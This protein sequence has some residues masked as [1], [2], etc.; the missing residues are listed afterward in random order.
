[1]LAFGQSAL[2]NYG[3]DYSDKTFMMGHENNRQ[4]KNLTSKYMV[5]VRHQ[6]LKNRFGSTPHGVLDSLVFFK[7]QS[8]GYAGFGKLNIYIKTTN[9]TFVD[10]LSW[11]FNQQKLSATQVFKSDRFR[12]DDASGPLVLHT[13]HRF[14]Y[15][16]S[17]NLMILVEWTRPD[18]ISCFKTRWKGK[19]VTDRTSMSW[20]GV[21]PKFS[22]TI[23][24]RFKVDM[25]LSFDSTAKICPDQSTFK[26]GEING[27]KFTVGLDTQNLES[28]LYVNFR[29]KNQEYSVY[30]NNQFEHLDTVN[31]VYPSTVYHV[32]TNNHCVPKGYQGE[33]HS[34]TIKTSCSIDLLDHIPYHQNFE[35]M[36]ADFGYESCWEY[37]DTTLAEDANNPHTGRHALLL[38]HNWNEWA[39]TPKIWLTAGTNYEVS[40]KYASE[41]NTV[42]VYIILGLDSVPIRNNTY[43]KIGEINRP[44]ND[45]YKTH[46]TVFSANKTGYY[47]LGIIRTGS[48]YKRVFIDD[49]VIRVHEACPLPELKSVIPGDHTIHFDFENDAAIEEYQVRVFNDDFDSTYV[50]SSGSFNTPGLLQNTSYFYESAS[51]CKDE[52]SSTT[53]AIRSILTLCKI[54]TLNRENPNVLQDYEDLTCIEDYTRIGSYIYT[55]QQGMSGNCVAGRNYTRLIGNH[56]YLQKNDTVLLEVYVAKEFQEPRFAGDSVPLFAYFVNGDFENSDTLNSTLDSIFFGEYKRAYTE[57]VASSEGIYSFGVGSAVRHNI[58]M[59]NFSISLRNNACNDV[60]NLEL[61][62]TQEDLL[63][64]KWSYEKPG[65]TS[66]FF[67]LR[68][69]KDV[70]IRYFSTADTSIQITGLIPRS[71][72]TV[73]MYFI[74]GTDTLLGQAPFVYHTPCALDT[75]KPNRPLHIDFESESEIKCFSHVTKDWLLYTSPG[76]EAYQRSRN[77]RGYFYIEKSNSTPTFEINPVYLT[78]DVNYGISALFAQDAQESRIWI[79]VIDSAGIVIKKDQLVLSPSDGNGSVY[80]EFT[81]AYSGIYRI[82]FKTGLRISVDDITVEHLD[83]C[84]AI[85]SQNL[86]VTSSGDTTQILLKSIAQQITRLDIRYGLTGTSLTYID[87]AVDSSRSIHLDLVLPGQSLFDLT[88]QTFCTNTNGTN[89]SFQFL[90][91]QKQVDTI[92]GTHP[93]QLDFDEYPAGKQSPFVDNGE[94]LGSPQI[95]IEENVGFPALSGSELI[96]ITQGLNE[97]IIPI[98]YFDTGII[99]RFSCFL[100]ART[101]QSKKVTLIVINQNYTDTAYVSNSVVNFGHTYIEI[102]RQFSINKPG[103]YAVKLQIEDR[104]APIFMDNLSITAS[105]LLKTPVSIVEWENSY[106]QVSLKWQHERKQEFDH[107]ELS[108]YERDSVLSGLPY[109]TITSIATSDSIV[110][111][112]GLP[113]NKEFWFRISGQNAQN[114]N[115]SVSP[116]QMVHTLATLDSSALRYTIRYTF[117]ASSQYGVVPMV[118]DTAS[119]AVLQAQEVALEYGYS[120]LNSLSGSNYINHP[121]YLLKDSVYSMSIAVRPNSRYDSKIYFSIDSI[122][123]SSQRVSLSDTF[124]LVRGTN[125]NVFARKFK[126]NESGYRKLSCSTILPNAQIHFDDFQ[127][128][129]SDPCLDQVDQMLAKNAVG[130]DWVEIQWRKPSL[131]SGYVVETVSNTSITRDTI[132]TIND[133]TY[134]INGLDLESI[135]SIRVGNQCGDLKWSKPIAHKTEPAVDTITNVRSYETSFEQPI[136]EK[137]S[138]LMYASQLKRTDITSAE[139]NYSLNYRAKSSTDTVRFLFAKV[140]LKAGKEYTV[141]YNRA[142]FNQSHENAVLYINDTLTT[143]GATAIGT[144]NTSQT[145]WRNIEFNK[146][147]VSKTGVYYIILESRFDHPFASLYLDDIVIK[148]HH[149]CKTFATLNLSIDRLTSNSATFSINNGYSANL[150][151]TYDLMTRNLGALVNYDHNYYH[152]PSGSTTIELKNLNTYTDYQISISAR[153]DVSDTTSYITPLPF[154]LTC[155]DSIH[156]V[157]ASNSYLENFEA[158][159]TNVLP[160]CW[161]G[162]S[163]FSGIV[164]T[165]NSNDRTLDWELR[166]YGGGNVTSKKLLLDSGVN[167]LISGDYTVFAKGGDSITIEVYDSKHQRLVDYE[168]FGNSTKASGLKTFQ[169]KFKPQGTSNYYLKLWNNSRSTTWISY[170]HFDEIS[171]QTEP[172]CKLDNVQLLPSSTG[173]K[174]VIISNSNTVSNTFVV[175]NKTLITTDTI[176]VPKHITYVDIPGSGYNSYQFEQQTSCGTSNS[177]KAF[178]TFKASNEAID[179]GEGWCEAFDHLLA[180]ELQDGWYATGVRGSGASNR[181]HST[182]NISFENTGHVPAVRSY[183]RNT[184][185]WDVHYAESPPI[186]FPYGGAFHVDMLY[187]VNHGEFD[188]Y[189]WNK[190]GADSISFA[191]YDIAEDSVIY[192][193]KPKVP[194]SQNA[195]VEYSADLYLKK[196]GNF[197]LRVY[198]HIQRPYVTN[199]NQYQKVYVTFDDICITPFDQEDCAAPRTSNI[200]LDTTLKQHVISWE[201]IPNAYSGYEWYLSNALDTTPIFSGFTFNQNSTRALLPDIPVG[202]SLRLFVRANCADKLDSQEVVRGGKTKPI[203]SFWSIGQPIIAPCRATYVDQE[204]IT[205]AFEDNST[206][207]PEC[208]SSSGDNSKVS[209]NHG[210]LYGKDSRGFLH[211][212]PQVNSSLKTNAFALQ[213]DS[214]YTISFDLMT[215]GRYSCDSILF[216]L[217]NQFNGRHKIGVLANEFEQSVYLNKTFNFK[218]PGNYDFS[219]ELLPFFSKT[220][221]SSGLAIDNFSIKQS[222]ACK[223]VDDWS[224]GC[225]DCDTVTLSL[226]NLLPITKLTLQTKSAIIPLDTALMGSNHSWDISRAVLGYDLQTLR[227]VR[228]CNSDTVISNQKLVPGI[229]HEAINVTDTTPFLSNFDNRYPQLRQTL[230]WNGNQVGKWYIESKKANHGPLSISPLD[231]D[232]LMYSSINPGDLSVKSSWLDLVQFATYDLSFWAKTTYGQNFNV[233]YMDTDSTIVWIATPNLNEKSWSKNQFDFKVNTSGKYRI[234]FQTSIGGLTGIDSVKLVRRPQSCSSDSMNQILSVGTNSVNIELAN[235]KSLTIGYLIT[236]ANNNTISGGYGTPKDVVNVSNLEPGKQYILYSNVVCPSGDTSFWSKSVEFKTDCLADTLAYGNTICTDFETTHQSPC[237]RMDNWNFGTDTLSNGLHTNNGKRFIYTNQKGLATYYSETITGN[238]GDAFDIGFT[239]LTHGPGLDS[240]Q[241]LLHHLD[242]D[243]LQILL[244]LRDTSFKQ[245]S[246]MNASASIQIQGAYRFVLQTGLQDEA[247]LLIDDICITRSRGCAPPKH[248]FID[249]LAKKTARVSWSRFADAKNGYAVDVEEMNQVNL[250][251]QSSFTTPT[252]LD[253]TIHLKNLKPGGNYRVTLMSLCDIPQVNDSTNEVSFVSLCPV[254]GIN[255]FNTIGAL[256]TSDSNWNCWE[257]S[258]PYNKGAWSFKDSIEYNGKTLSGFDVVAPDYLSVKG[259]DSLSTSATDEVKTPW[260]HLDPV[261]MISFRLTDNYFKSGMGEFLTENNTFYVG[262][263]DS[264]ILGKLDTLVTFNGDVKSAWSTMSLEVPGGISTGRFVFG[265]TRDALKPYRNDYAI[266]HIKLR[267]DSCNTIFSVHSNASSNNHICLTQ[268]EELYLGGDNDLSLTLKRKSDLAVSYNLFNMLYETSA[269]EVSDSVQFDVGNKHIVSLMKISTENVDQNR[270]DAVNEV[271]FILPHAALSSVID[272]ARNISAHFRWIDITDLWFYSTDSMLAPVVNGMSNVKEPEL[273]RLK[274]GS[275]VSNTNWQL[276]TVL[277]GS[278]VTIRGSVVKSN[279]TLGLSL[280]DEPSSSNVL[281]LSEIR[282]YPNP[283]SNDITIQPI[284]FIGIDHVVVKD[285]LGK[286]VLDQRWNNV[287]EPITL[288]LSSLEAGTYYIQINQSTGIGVLKIIKI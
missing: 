272:T 31:Y 92:N 25:M 3:N 285:V 253:T 260:L 66:A 287:T 158:H 222:N 166:M 59:D 36:F 108:V 22:T 72:Y 101:V 68:G 9:D 77:G 226:G 227:L 62:P 39:S 267:T 282:I 249:S 280:K 231:G 212:T 103:N 174:G 250:V 199:P 157:T 163:R 129:K 269:M 55:K 40:F 159:S 186:A 189:S 133:T 165:R 6:E 215:D 216:T 107:L 97:L 34:K 56:V 257:F 104:T 130:K 114:E 41:N 88:I 20:V 147:T 83:F 10:V 71:F 259:R 205:Y 124:S 136:D 168:I 30:E 144:S 237:Y 48:Q 195:T 181:I 273:T 54:D 90:T 276:D 51:R 117:D 135:Y 119:N 229:H 17:S 112:S 120:G 206:S 123:G 235:N 60:I 233:G 232:F 50:S 43:T 238:Y 82:R 14:S 78:R 156:H 210:A 279:M 116:A 245:F 234:V 179:I 218:S 115:L 127:I 188:S 185:T 27:Q 268:G 47:Y 194:T 248:I 155:F 49:L 265:I 149:T 16:D 128:G 29:N 236:D 254:Y 37:D 24:S 143:K 244:N 87:T 63:H 131:S 240:M 266:D 74:C 224:I 137:L 201:K 145:A 207:L 169:M 217:V 239:G 45:Q 277:Q 99:Y 61:I 193:G 91:A 283:T 230:H 183:L 2:F 220:Y 160:E 65:Q 228:T 251:G 256:S 70:S 209:L 95:A 76:Q 141:N 26:E 79:E 23:D 32:H 1:M 271:G 284:G 113:F 106:D 21:K 153:C 286:T 242:T 191:L 142:V 75:I 100:N 278:K 80:S 8:C 132:T 81:P 42:P 57:F 96:E 15:E 176:V 223:S 263:E 110:A 52:R 175:H 98:H 214:M 146:L 264:A 19:I 126:V 221:L 102:I 171:V 184:L 28:R 121:V 4:Y 109:K 53:N 241:V 46:T 172:D 154:T 197:K 161:D 84:H 7:D 33:D 138:C 18:I 219:I 255:E 150:G 196:S 200:N 122:P 58:V 134:R 202:D 64:M 208:W 118:S 177:I 86:E 192:F 111:I 164:R 67:K 182:E 44:N 190:L 258:N 125:W 11:K 105:S 170:I 225:I 288:D 246:R 243:S 252:S 281:E 173:V 213:K 5:I 178:Y 35:S 94:D 38:Y 162:D 270:L 187:M 275:T 73:E 69:N 247:T 274:H 211:I 203:L 93:L 12:I 13:N 152:L 89:R 262:V 139:G 204:A 198:L 167:Y 85:S 180:K 140:Y 148:E 151:F 261:N